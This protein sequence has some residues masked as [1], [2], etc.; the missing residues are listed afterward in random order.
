MVVILSCA[1]TSGCQH[2]VAPPASSP[3]FVP[4]Q[5]PTPAPVPEPAPSSV[6]VNYYRSGGIAGVQDRLTV[7][8]DGRCELQRRTAQREFTLQPDYIRYLK[9]LLEKADFPAL[10]EEYLTPVGADLM[11]LIITYKTSGK[12]YTVHTDDGAI[13]DSLQTVIAEMNKVIADHS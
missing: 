2:K 6:L 9:D 7:Y 10:K 12:K 1:A 8:Y 13:P 11:D 4:S 5:S 3:P